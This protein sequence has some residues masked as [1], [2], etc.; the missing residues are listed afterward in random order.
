MRNEIF[1]VWLS[2]PRRINIDDEDELRNWCQSLGVT[3]AQ[4]KSVVE[5]V[6]PM[7]DKVS[8]E[9]RGG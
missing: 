9:L 6:G 4:L 7:A 3:P 5:K 1:N 2:D 8:E